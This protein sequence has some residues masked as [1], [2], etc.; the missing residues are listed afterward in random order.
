MNIRIT[1]SS[2]KT[3]ENKRA[4][5]FDC[6]AKNYR[7]KINTGILVEEEYFEETK[8]TLSISLNITFDKL[9][10]K[11]ED[12]LAKYFKYNW[13]KEELET[14]LKKGI[15]LYSI[16]EYV[17]KDF[18]K[19]KNLITANDYQNVV[20]VFK[21]HLNKANIHFNDILEE[22]TIHKFK[23][24]AEKRGVKSSS[25][26]SYI[27]KM[28]VIMN[29]AKRDGF[30]TKKF[31]IPRYIIEKRQKLVLKKN[32]DKNRFIRAVNESEDIFEIQALSIFLMLL[33][34][35]GMSPSNLINYKVIENK[36]KKD[37]ISLMLFEKNSIVI[38]F[39]KS[40][41]GEAVKYVKLDYTKIKIIELVKTLFYLTHHK[42][43]PF[44]LSAYSSYHSIFNFDIQ[45]NNNFYRNFWNF[46]QVK[47]KEK[48][49]LKFSDAKSIYYQ[50][51]KEIEMNKVSSD[52]MFSK[53]RTSEIIT[54]QNTDVL[55]QN[56]EK[57]EQKMMKNLSASELTQVIINR[58]VFLGV[59]L[60]K[61]SLNDVKTPSDFSAFLHEISKFHTN[62]KN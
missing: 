13:S 11:K 59:D 32:F 41:K 50:S 45:K 21:K 26:N 44:I 58:L 4:I 27:K 10:S 5:I 12:A 6:S 53:V 1:K 61:F 39:K 43:Y 37:L 30:I 23:Y 34:C 49:D 62:L 7:K 18:V 52:V 35:G 19:N 38:K 31:V 60:N 42:K 16:E 2:Y 28:S 15:E 3:K 55:K 17:K 46:F 33:V 8:T 20:K 51:L 14:Y 56:I 24:N 9:K 22:N 47:I 25:I 48:Y 36:K 40:N 54:L 57:Y 29:Q